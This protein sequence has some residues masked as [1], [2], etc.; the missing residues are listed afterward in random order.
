MF[1]RA[2]VVA[3]VVVL[4]SLTTTIVK[5]W[6][7]KIVIASQTSPD[8]SVTAFVTDTQA[9]WLDGP[10]DSLWLSR[11]AGERPVLLAKLGED[12][13]WCHDIRWTPDGRTVGFLITQRH[14]WLYSAFPAHPLREVDLVPMARGYPPEP[15]VSRLAFG[16]DGRSVR[17][18][19]QGGESETPQEVLLRLQ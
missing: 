13:D 18:T 4:A 15:H 12:Q 7:R 17:Y 10:A 2:L 6:P 9:P 11:A 1:R 3:G 14:L 16:A 8:G 5:L 19:V